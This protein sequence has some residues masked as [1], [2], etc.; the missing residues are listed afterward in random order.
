[1]KIH[2]VGK[3]KPYLLAIISLTY[4]NVS[5]AQDDSLLIQKRKFQSRIYWD[6]GQTLMLGKYISET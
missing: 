3:M 4:I 2:L 6:Y 5:A 1:M